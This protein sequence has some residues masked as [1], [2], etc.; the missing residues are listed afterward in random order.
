[1]YE[2]YTRQALP[3][4]NYRELLGSAICIF[5]SNNAFII[6]NILKNDD[7][8]QYNWYNLIDRTSGC[9]KSPIRETIIEASENSIVNLFDSICEKRNRI[10]HSFQITDTD[11][12]QRLATK[13]KSNVQ[14]VITEE[15]L[16]DF[17]QENEQLSTE[18]HRFRGY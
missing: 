14:Y 2:N 11:G 9:L 16:K 5:N 1:M 18:L 17:I 7:K 8:S 12:E 3:S 15:F 13:N 4:K 10:I 6:E